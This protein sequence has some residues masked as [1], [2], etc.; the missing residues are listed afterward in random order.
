MEYGAEPPYPEDDEYEFDHDEPGQW[1][2]GDEP[3]TTDLA[4]PQPAAAPAPVSETAV[5]SA[6]LQAIVDAAERSAEE[7]RLHAEQRAADRI[8][9]AD[10]AAAIRVQ[11][12]EEEAAEI[13]AEAQAKAAAE[14]AEAVNTVDSIHAEAHEALREAKEKAQETIVQARADAREIVRAAHQA[15]GEVL[16]DGS[17]LADQLRELSGSLR[18]NAER[19]LRDIRLAHGS[20]TARLDQATPEGARWRAGDPSPPARRRTRAADEDA[21]VDFDVPDFIVRDE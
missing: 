7:M 21:A 1:L 15:T 19:L 20:M 18:S 5:L 10:R 16:D 11:A 12:A 8:A 6:R 3:E 17:E 4:E 2:P 14:A 9:E 13:V